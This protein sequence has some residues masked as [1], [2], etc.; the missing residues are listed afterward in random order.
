MA[1]LT[2]ILTNSGGTTPAGTVMAFAS[3]TAPA[4][5]IKANGAQIGRVAY[6]DLFAVCGTT[7]G[8]GNG[9]TTFTIPDLRGEFIRGWDDARGVDSGRTFG[10]AQDHM[11]SNHTH[12][13]QYYRTNFSYQ[14]HYS[15]NYM[16]NGET[17]QSV[18]TGNPNAGGPYG[19]ET[20]PRNVSLLYC[21]KY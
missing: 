6:A 18:S 16:G 4:G 5:Y 19:S 13:F 11:L 10:S 21:I 3:S 9:S 20:R 8:S 2:G 17:L 15:P 14:G 7:F 12:S 1:T